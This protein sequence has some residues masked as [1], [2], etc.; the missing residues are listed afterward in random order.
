[1]CQY[2]G[3]DYNS[4]Q[5]KLKNNYKTRNVNSFNNIAKQNIGRNIG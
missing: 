3:P 4:Y 1:M 5:E 2:T